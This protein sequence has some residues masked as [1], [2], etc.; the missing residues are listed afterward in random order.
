MCYI[1]LIET[2]KLYMRGLC[3]IEPEWLAQYL[4]NECS[5]GRPIVDSTT[6]T[7]LPRFDQERGVVVCH[8]EASFGKL[9]WKIRP[10]EVEWLPPELELFKWFAQFLLEGKVI[11]GLKKYEAVLLGAPTTMLKSWAK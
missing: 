2:S 9:M 10:V 5:F 4:P 7:M 1:D 11:D 6:T 3:A 8:R